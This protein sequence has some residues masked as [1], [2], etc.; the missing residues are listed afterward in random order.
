MLCNPFLS[1]GQIN[2]RL[3]QHFLDVF[4]IS[5]DMLLPIIVAAGPKAWNVFYLSNVG[6]VG[7][8]L[9]LGLFYVC[10]ALYR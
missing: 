1:N 6:I 8:N 4:S 3:Q 9:T 7:S 10:V 2:T 5:E